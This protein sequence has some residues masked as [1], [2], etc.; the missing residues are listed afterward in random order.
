MATPCDPKSILTLAIGLIPHLIPATTIP[1]GLISRAMTEPLAEGRDEVIYLICSHPRVALG[2]R[3]SD[4]WREVYAADGGIGGPVCYADDRPWARVRFPEG[5]RPSALGWAVLD[6]HLEMVEGLV[7]DFSFDPSQDP[8]GVD[9]RH[10]QE[11]LPW[12]YDRHLELGRELETFR[13]SV[14]GGDIA[15]RVEYIGRAGNDALL[16]A[17]GPHHKMPLIL[18]RMLTYDP[19]RLVYTLPCSI[20]ATVMD[21]DA[22]ESVLVPPLVEAVAQT[23][24]PRDLIIAAAE[25]VLIAGL[26][27]PENRSNTAARRFPFSKTAEKLCDAGV[28]QV[29]V[30]FLTIPMRVTIRGEHRTFEQGDAAIRRE[31]PSRRA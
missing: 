18:S 9:G 20:N 2:Q 10:R 25:E 14:E 21:S 26:G 22:G 27:A 16:R 13:G 1:A 19:H 3:V 11:L 12:I 5:V 8:E 7:P 29:V 31:L 24:L 30:G 6:P 15:F 4:G 28:D 23:G 17:T